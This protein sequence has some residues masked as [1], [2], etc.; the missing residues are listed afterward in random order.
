M[1]S[2]NQ[3][4]GR[5][6]QS[7]DGVMVEWYDNDAMAPRSP[8]NERS[9][10]STAEVAVEEFIASGHSAPLAEFMPIE[11]RIMVSAGCR[12][13]GIAT[14]TATFPP[15]AILP[16]HVH[17]CGEAIT[18]LDGQADVSVMGRRYQLSRL[19]CIYV[20]E[21]TA[22]SVANFDTASLLIAH[23]AFSNS[24]PGR[25]LVPDLFHD[26]N[27][28][29][30]LPNAGEPERLRRFGQA[31]MYPLAEGT[32]FYDLFAS[33][34]GSVG[35]CGGYGEFDPGTALPCHIHKFDESITIITGQSVCR[36]QGKQHTL[37]N[38]D[39]A[40][41]PEGK[42]HCFLNQSGSPMAMI[43]VYAGN[44]PERTLVSA[45]YCLGLQAW[46]GA[47]RLEGT[48]RGQLDI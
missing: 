43:W 13:K 7:I 20:P 39:T 25:I 5:C 6:K 29:A 9:L 12:A 42:P 35:M 14:G 30:G 19:D 21:G 36:V 11:L 22:H 17:E 48:D 40:F 28:G 31:E 38:C 16:Y 8:E 3:T 32:R 23:S 1:P 34:F 18:I 27:R 44:E 10:A 46:P 47:H 4:I 2:Y 24:S 26:E 45:E 41:V 33:R 37:S 15:G